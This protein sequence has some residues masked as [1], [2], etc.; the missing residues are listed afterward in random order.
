MSK[1]KKVN[2]YGTRIPVHAIDSFAR[3]LLPDIQ[4]FFES[5][6]GKQEFEAW[7]AKKA[8]AEEDYKLKDDM[9]VNDYGD[10]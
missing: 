8:Q 6:E 2:D 3:C 10:H 5:K 1:P 9:E 4:R 7:Q